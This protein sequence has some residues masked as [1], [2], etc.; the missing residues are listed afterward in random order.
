MKVDDVGEIKETLEQTKESSVVKNSSPSDDLKDMEIKIGKKVYA[1]PVC[2]SDLVE[3]G[4]GID[5][6][7][8]MNPNTS[9][10]PKD[11]PGIF[12]PGPV[13]DKKGKV[14]YMAYE[15]SGNTLRSIANCHI[16]SMTITEESEKCS[17]AK[18][19][20]IGSGQQEVLEAFGKKKVENDTIEYSYKTKK[21]QGQAKFTLDKGKISQINMILTEQ[22]Q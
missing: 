18:G 16:A 5:D 13:S 9:D 19:I 22:N 12:Y 6:S 15:N 17:I 11:F 7:W 10:V 1:M 8:V 21:G 14:F 3:L 2:A 20:H 4:Y